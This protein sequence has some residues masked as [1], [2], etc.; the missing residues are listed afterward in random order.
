MGI[1]L[2]EKSKTNLT[3]TDTK[4]ESTN[5]LIV[6]LYVQITG[7]ACQHHVSLLVDLSLRMGIPLMLN[8]CLSVLGK[9]VEKLLRMGIL[10]I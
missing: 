1:L 5:I 7:T 9:S 3:C 4:V 2:W 10:V 8:S 6:K